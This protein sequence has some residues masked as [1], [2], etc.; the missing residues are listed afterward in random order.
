MHPPFRALAAIVGWA[1]PSPRADTP[2]PRCDRRPGEKKVPCACLEEE[3]PAGLGSSLHRLPAPRRCPRPTRLPGT[4]SQPRLRAR[5]LPSPRG[6]RTAT[7]ARAPLRTSAGAEPER[8]QGRA[9]RSEKE[10]A[11]AAAAASNRSGR[12]ELT[13]SAVGLFF[14]WL[15]SPKPFNLEHLAFLMALA[16]GQRAVFSASRWALPFPSWAPVV[17]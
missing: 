12:C 7:S 10:A 6:G 15:I 8:A 11:A 3:A 4:R 16:L 1:F 13:R 9:R 5:A 14:F 17:V 2:S